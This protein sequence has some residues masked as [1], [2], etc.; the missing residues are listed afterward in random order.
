MTATLE[1]TAEL[2]RLLG[3]DHLAR[4]PKPLGE[5]SPS[6]EW[7]TWF[8]WPLE[9]RRRLLRYMAPAGSGLAP[10][11]AAMVMGLEASATR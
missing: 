11:D 2:D 5:R 3:S 9:D 8:T 6:G 1:S 10:D 4:P 7:D